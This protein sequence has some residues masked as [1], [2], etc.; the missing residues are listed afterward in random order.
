MKKQSFITGAIILMIANAVSK[1]LGAVFKIPLTYI[2]KEEGMAVFNIS[3]QIY[4]MVLSFIISG[5]PFAI[6]KLVAEFIS[7][8]EYDKV[9]RT[10]NLSTLILIIIGIAGSLLLYFGASFFALAMKEEKAVYAIKAI[11]PAVFFVALGTAYKSYFQGASNMIPT[12]VSQVV[13]AVVKLFAGY[14]LAVFF[15]SY[16]TAKTAAGA[17]MGVTAGEIIATAI[18]MIGY[19][20]SR[21]KKNKI[22]IKQKNSEIIKSL[23]CIAIPLLCASVVTDMLNV[24]DTTLVRTRLLDA[25][26]SSEEARFLYGAY[27]GYALTVFHLPVG[28]LATLGV[29]ILPVISGAI[30]VGNT[31]RAQK[32][33]KTALELTIFAAV[34]CSVVLFTESENILKLLFN[35]PSSAVMLTVVSP[36]VIMM[37]V[38][39]IS[40]AVLQSSNKI[41]LPFFFSL[42]CSLIKLVISY[43]LVGCRE[44]NIYGSAISANISSFIMMILSLAAVKRHLCLKFD[45]KAIIIKPAAAA[46]A[47]CTVIYFLKAPLNELCKSSFSELFITC[48]VS[49]TV[50]LLM[51][52]LTRAVS[53]KELRK[54]LK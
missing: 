44:Y 38:S 17:V 19:F 14:A 11:S 26:L 41:M 6:S 20:F 12:A 36:C 39:Q 37:C 34:P 52:I 48:A 4:I 29:S 28:I 51:L 16:G 40:S 43:M 30:A 23:M 5:F 45:F 2:L 49:C 33:T 53:F 8:R 10:V 24:V 9:R 1:I 22:S 32:T 3:F 18:L 47:M 27:T 35:N 31:E 7:K 21:Y 25:G 50:Y 15:V 13:E 46:A 54:V 42:I